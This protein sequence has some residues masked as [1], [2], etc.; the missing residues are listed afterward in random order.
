[1]GRGPGQSG[2][3]FTF[4]NGKGEGFIIWKKKRFFHAY[5]N[6]VVLY[7]KLRYQNFL[8]ISISYVKS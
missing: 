8:M 7:D 1:M 6:C 2:P 3:S 5:A 4:E